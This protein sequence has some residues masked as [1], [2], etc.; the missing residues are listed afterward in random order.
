MEQVFFKYCVYHFLAPEHFLFHTFK[1][2]HSI[3]IAAESDTKLFNI[4]ILK[5]S[6]Q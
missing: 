5:Y 4:F 1:D 2:I 6:I 3:R